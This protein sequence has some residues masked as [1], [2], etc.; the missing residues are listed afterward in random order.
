MN[1]LIKVV[2]RKFLHIVLHENT[3]QCKFHL[4]SLFITFIQRDLD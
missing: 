4:L 3:E 2:H 1:C